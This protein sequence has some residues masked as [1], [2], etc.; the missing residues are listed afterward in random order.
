MCQVE[1]GDPPAG[2]LGAGDGAERGR[3][4]HSCGGLTCEKRAHRR[5]LPAATGIMD[6]SLLVDL[7]F[8]FVF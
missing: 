1:R 2:A 6:L 4:V 5:S 8:A 3:R 7:F